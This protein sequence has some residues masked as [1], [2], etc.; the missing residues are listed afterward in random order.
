[1]KRARPTEVHQLLAALSYG[2]AIGNEALA[3]QKYLRAA[4]LGSDIFCEHVHPRV[5]HCARPLWEYKEVSGPETVCLFH[6]SIGSAAGP[7]LYHAHDR[8]VIIYHNITPAHFFLGFHPHLAGLCYNGRRE[9]AAFAP[10]AELA[11]GDSEF[12][13]Q[14][15]VEAG[16]QRT[17]VLPIVLDP[18][19]YALEPSPVIARLYGDRRTNILFVGRIIPNKRIDDLIRV[20]A[21]YQRYIEADSRLLLVGDYRGHERY[22]ARLTEMVDQLRL[23]DVVFTGHV[24][25]SDLLSYYRAADV[26]LCLSE[27]EGYCVPLVEAMLLGVP[28]VAYDAGAVRDTLRGGGVLL[29]DKSPELV[30]ELLGSVVSEPPLRQAILA[31]QA[32]AVAELRQ[33]RQSDVLM[34]QLAP[35]LDETAPD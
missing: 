27:H 29:K 32:R 12:N 34:R 24:D 11:L 26:F 17:G 33:V 31:T 10:R 25:D 23:R 3:I 5:A 6:F 1:M 13:R 2:D 30:A 8:V 19:R 20:F 4:G 9:L 15:L 35:V 16:Y 7:L 21:V 14:E 18:T 28:I 22:F